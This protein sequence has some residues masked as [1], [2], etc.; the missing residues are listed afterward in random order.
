[1]SEDKTKENKENDNSLNN[2]SLES[3]VYDNKSQLS[4]ESNLDSFTI[5]FPDKVKM[6]KNEIPAAM[7]KLD[8]TKVNEKYQSSVNNM[9]GK[10]N[11]NV[12]AQN[13]KKKLEKKKPVQKN[14]DNDLDLI[15]EKLKNDMKNSIIAVKDMNGKLEK[16]KNLNK[17]LKQKIVKLNENLKMS[18]TKI[19]FLESQIEK[20]E[21]DSRKNTTIVY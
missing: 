7:F 15:I 13:N 11:V 4:D 3:E 17:D 9:K 20:I 12:L 8:F 14:D 5:K 6:Q 19:E 1:M 10:L 18:N 21:S 2:Y 16:H